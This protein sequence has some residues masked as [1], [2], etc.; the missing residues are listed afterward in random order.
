MK[1]I[2]IIGLGQLG[3]RHLQAL[4]LVKE[5][6]NIELVDISKDSLEIA[7]ERFYEV[8]NSKNF[9]GAIKKLN[10]IDELSADLDLVIIASNSKERR[11]IT[12]KLL[13]TK[14]VTHL[15]LEKVLFPT[16][17]DYAEISEL[18]SAKKINT[19]VN[20]SRRSMPSYRKIKELLIKGEPLDVTIAG[21]SWGMGSNGIHFIDLFCFLVGSSELTLDTTMLDKLNPIESTR[22]GYLDFTGT[23]TGRSKNRDTFKMS[24]YA[25]GK[26]PVQVI[27]QSGSQ[28]MIINEYQN[29]Y[30]LY[31]EKNNWKGDVFDFEML[32]QSKLTA[33][34]TE[35]ILRTGTCDLTP[36]TEAAAE[37]KAFLNALI[38]FQTKRTGKRVETCMIT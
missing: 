37:H 14:K 35:D 3:S 7:Y 25:D 4:A 2:A 1:N 13:Q 32:F 31:N 28:R 27:I 20:C 23:I 33:M 9:K 11:P 17:E 6:L 8:E 29:N 22:K 21:S 36:Y 19:W 5:P 15:I 16:L 30:I 26:L 18:L 12:E 10:S 38:Q 34:V 24:S